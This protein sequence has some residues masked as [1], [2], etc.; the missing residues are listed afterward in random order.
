[1]KNV[2]GGGGE[3][4]VSILYMNKNSIVREGKYLGITILIILIDGNYLVYLS[5]DFKG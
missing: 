1:M 5:P 3:Q 4:E 2:G